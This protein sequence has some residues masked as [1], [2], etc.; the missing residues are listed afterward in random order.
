MLASVLVWLHWLLIAEKVCVNPCVCPPTH[1]KTHAL[2][3]DV[4]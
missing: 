1:N 2:F 3:T 4:Y